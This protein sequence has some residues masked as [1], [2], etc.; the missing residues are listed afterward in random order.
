MWLVG[1]SKEVILGVDMWIGCDEK[2]ILSEDLRLHLY[3]RGYFYLIDIMGDECERFGTQLWLSSQR[4][5]L[6]GE[7]EIE[8]NQYIS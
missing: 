6:I 7:V 4:L 8:W 1:S 5:E 3:S 2:Q